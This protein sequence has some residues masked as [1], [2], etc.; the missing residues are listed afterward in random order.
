LETQQLRTLVLDAMGVIYR[1]GND[2]TDLFC[3]FVKEKGG[4]EDVARIL[5]L[6]RAASLGEISSAD[7]WQGVGLD[8]Q[9]EDEYLRRYELT[10]RLMDFLE[11]VDS[12]GYELWCLSNDI[13]EWS[14]KLRARFALDRYVSGFVI[15][16]DV[17][18]RKPDR[19]I[20]DHLINLM[21]AE[22]HD[23]VFIDDQQINLDAA[24]T[25]GFRTILFLP[26]GYDSAGERHVPATGFTDIL[27]WLDS[28]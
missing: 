14:K 6:Y 25:M 7:L 5:A 2:N 4:T 1:V 19:A 15:S 20:F 9:L 10:E 27:R 3:P 22:P 23:A 28:R 11:V 21:A 26:G 13:S 24:A 8:P 17:R 12:Q 16:G 18:I